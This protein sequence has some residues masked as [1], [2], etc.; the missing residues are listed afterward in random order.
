MRTV[1]Q[2]RP[3]EPTLFTGRPPRLATS[4]ESCARRSS[5]A[6]CC[7]AHVQVPGRAVRTSSTTSLSRRAMHTV[8]LPPTAPARAGVRRPRRGPSSCVARTQPGSIDSITCP[9]ASARSRSRRG[10]E[11]TSCSCRLSADT[12]GEHWSTLVSPRVPSPRRGA[13]HAR[14]A[15]TVFTPPNEG[16]KTANVATRGTAQLRTAAA[17]AGSA[18]RRV[19]L[20]DGADAIPTS[21][22]N[23]SNRTVDGWR[24]PRARRLPVT[25]VTT[26]TTTDA[27][28]IH[29]IAGPI[30]RSVCPY[31]GRGPA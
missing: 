31:P 14:A 24:Q 19:G 23:P 29:E 26:P 27:R 30:H 1:V 8:V 3:N 18:G 5:N 15:S 22:W 6:T 21:S 7:R 9:P 4:L 20:G 25:Q 17:P 11:I 13:A 10:T 12:R 28:A 2:C 16:S